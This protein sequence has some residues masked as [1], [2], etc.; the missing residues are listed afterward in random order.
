LKKKKEKAEVSKA[1]G[2]K[3]F[4]P[5]KTEGGA[6]KAKRGQWN[7]DLSWGKIEGERSGRCHEKLCGKEKCAKE[8]GIEGIRR[9]K[10]S[11]LE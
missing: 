9:G 2:G 3:E 7:P 8:G 1:K 11:S 5:R 10:E 6:T 4:R